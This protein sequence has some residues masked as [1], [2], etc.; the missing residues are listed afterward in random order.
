MNQLCEHCRDIPFAALSCPTADDIIE[1]RQAKRDGVKYPQLLPFRKS[2]AEQFDSPDT[3]LGSLKDIYHRSAVCS[4]CRLIY[5]AVQKR[6][7][8]YYDGRP[9]PEND[10]NIMFAATMDRMYFAYI[11]ES[12]TD[13]AA[14]GASDSLCILRRLG[15]AVSFHESTEVD[16]RV[17]PPGIGIAHYSQIAQVCHVLDYDET[18]LLSTH[19]RDV[20]RPP[21]MLFGGRRRPDMVDTKL[22]RFWLEVCEGSHDETC[23]DPEISSSVPW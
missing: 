5:E 16:G 7:A 15:L 13:T 23:C 1:I 20:I 9:I 18:A 3:N 19:D 22:L 10:D 14:N 21:R 11:T 2:F 4:L 6:G 17:I 12:I 8:V